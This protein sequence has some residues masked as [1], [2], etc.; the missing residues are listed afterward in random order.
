MA[1]SLARPAKRIV[2]L[3]PSVTESLFCLGLGERIV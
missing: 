2:S 3:V 1:N